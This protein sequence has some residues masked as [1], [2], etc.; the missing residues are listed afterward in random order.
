MNLPSLTPSRLAIA[1]TVAVLSLFSVPSL[2]QRSPYNAGFAGNAGNA[3]ALPPAL[4]AAVLSGNGHAVQNAIV[5]LSRGNPMQAA[6]LAEQVATASEKMLN[7][8]PQ[9]A[10][11]NV[12]AA[13]QVVSDR[14]VQSASPGQAQRVFTTA[15]RMI[16]SPQAAATSPDVVAMIAQALREAGFQ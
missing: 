5:T 8:N 6:S 10:L 11:S 1:L 3:G 13:V 4:N 12:A 2:A 7:T 16:S 15:A 14:S 9:A